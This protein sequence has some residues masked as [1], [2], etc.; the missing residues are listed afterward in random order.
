METAGTGGKQPHVF[1]R[2]ELL[3]QVEVYLVVTHWPHNY[4]VKDA[5]G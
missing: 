4:S 5:D 2:E 3:P 1:V